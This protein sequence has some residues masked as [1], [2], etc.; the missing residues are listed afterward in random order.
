M[1]SISQISISFMNEN[2]MLVLIDVNGV[3]LAL[4]IKE[5]LFLDFQ[6]VSLVIKDYV[7]RSQFFPNFFESNH[8]TVSVQESPLKVCVTGGEIYVYCLVESLLTI[9]NHFS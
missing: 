6:I 3:T 4:G 9:F 1:I 2:S 5:A 8:F 7:K